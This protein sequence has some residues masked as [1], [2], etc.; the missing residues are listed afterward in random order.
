MTRRTSQ[1]DYAPPPV[2]AAIDR[3]VK[4]VLG[5][6]LLALAAFC[7]FGFLASFELRGRAGLPWK[8]GYA[9]AGLALIATAA[10][11]FCGALTGRPRARS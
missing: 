5:V 10:W 3:A 9:A 4:A 8:V 11:L 1:L 2:P 7:A 6:V